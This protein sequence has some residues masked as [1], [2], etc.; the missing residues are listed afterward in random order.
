MV[1]LGREVVDN[2]ERGRASGYGKREKRGE[3]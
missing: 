2:R 3:I 1:G